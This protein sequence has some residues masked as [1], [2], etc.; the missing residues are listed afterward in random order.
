MPTLLTFH[1]VDDVDH[2][3]GSPKREEVFGALGITTRTFR[4]PEGSNRVG[5]IVEVPDMAAFEEVMQSEAGAEAMKFD[6][7]R[8]ETLLVLT[9]G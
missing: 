1:E 6:G 8:P 9:E 5:L 3:F 7:V 4:D 2:W